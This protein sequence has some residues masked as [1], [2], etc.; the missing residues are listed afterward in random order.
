MKTSI[1]CFE[2]VNSEIDIDSSLRQSR[3]YMLQWQ[4]H[5]R[6]RQFYVSINLNSIKMK[7]LIYILTTILLF[8]CGES[9]TIGKY[10]KQP[11]PK[12]FTFKIIQD[13]SNDALEKN[14]LVIEISEKITIEQIAT[15]ADKFY[16]SRPK[17]RRFYIAYLLPSMKNDGSG[18]WA[19]SHF[20]PELEI[21]I[22][23]STEN[24]DVKTSETSD[25]SGTIIYKWRNEKSLSG[26]V[27]VL[28]KNSENKLIMRIIFKDGAKLESEI[29]ESTQN[30]KSRYSDDNK[31]GEYYILE[32]NGNLG[33]YG[34]DGKFD[35]AIIIK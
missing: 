8:S 34:N 1:I 11:L 21:D 25:I 13:K 32:S 26:A 19:T 22:I 33:L 9:S 17:Q 24:Q 16:S 4:I 18:C 28:Y 6:Y 29:K 14:Q 35:E 20:D 23:G 15:L 31:H 2:T 12:D 27:L 3:K 5:N 30:G 7:K 10:K